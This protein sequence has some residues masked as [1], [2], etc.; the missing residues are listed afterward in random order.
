MNHTINY[1]Q[2]TSTIHAS[3]ESIVQASDIQS[4][5]FETTSAISPRASARQFLS[6]SPSPKI[7]SSADTPIQNN[8][9]TYI[10]GEAPEKAVDSNSLRI[11]S[12]NICGTEFSP[13]YG[14]V[15]PWKHRIQ[16]IVQKIRET[17]PDVMVLQEVYDP[18]A[19]EILVDALKDLYPHF[20]IHLGPNDQG[21]EGGCMVF[22]KFPI[23]NFSN[24]SF[25]NNTPHLNRGFA[26][27]EIKAKPEDTVPFLR[28]IGTH[29]MYGYTAEDIEKRAQQIEQIKAH[30]A[31]LDT[32]PTLIAADFNIERDDP[33]LSFLEHGYKGDQSTCMTTGLLR[34][35]DP[36]A[37]GP[38][39]EWIDN[40]SLVKGSEGSIE[41]HL[42]QGFNP[43][44]LDPE[45]ALS[46][47]HLLIGT[48]THSSIEQKQI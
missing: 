45:T 46:D 34:K 47:H 37:Q 13:I 25:T 28:I 11:G 15:I 35:W 10:P 7:S 22:S 33:I 17:N 3:S 32:C 30:L 2:N 4:Y 41:A 40:I 14:G 19:P 42:I 23:H 26:T 6:N 24:T 21:A 12:W 8:D 1:L 39:E 16:G 31:T 43:K 48:Y 36:N 29:I 5:T 27:L 9:Y 20:F 18:G 38:D 44:S